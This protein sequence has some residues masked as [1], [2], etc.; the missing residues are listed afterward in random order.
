MP[1]SRDSSLQ[2]NSDCWLSRKVAAWQRVC[3]GFERTDG[4]GLGTL[5]CRS[6]VRIVASTVTSAEAVR[7]VSVWAAVTKSHAAYQS[8]CGLRAMHHLHNKVKRCKQLRGAARSA[9]SIGARCVCRVRQAG[10]DRR[11][12]MH[13]HH[14][15]QFILVRS[16][17][18]QE[19]TCATE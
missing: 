6:D 12:R 13:T 17:T 16:V 18:E 4:T 3:V 9:V 15:P 11:S 14:Q 2:D 1:I 8:Q 5:I 10:L 19:G 7:S